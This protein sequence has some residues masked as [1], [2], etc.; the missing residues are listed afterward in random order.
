MNL[1]CVLG[2]SNLI[3]YLFVKHPGDNFGDNSPSRQVLLE[4]VLEIHRM[5]PLLDLLSYPERCVIGG[6]MADT[7]TIIEQAY[8]AFNERDIDG[9]LALMAEDVS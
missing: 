4:A 6:Y 1:N 9:A 3:C 7:K 2:D 5:R 8:S